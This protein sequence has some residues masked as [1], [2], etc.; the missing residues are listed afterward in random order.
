M[1][2]T[3]RFEFVVK[4]PP[5]ASREV[6]EFIA[7]FRYNQG[8]TCPEPIYK[9]MTRDYQY[10]FAVMLQKAFGRGE[11]RYIEKYN[12]IIWY[13][14]ESCMLYDIDGV[15]RTGCDSVPIQVAANKGINYK[16]LPDIQLS[17][18]RAGVK[19][20]KPKS[21][22]R[23]GFFAVNG[24]KYTWIDLIHKGYIEV[25][26][27]GAL[28]APNFKDLP[29]GMLQVDESVKII[30]NRAFA[31]AHNLVEILLP[32]NL[33][34]IETR[35]FSTC[36]LTDLYVPASVTSIGAAAFDGIPR[37]HY[38]GNAEG[39]PWHAL[40]VISETPAFNSKEYLLENLGNMYEYVPTC[41]IEDCKTKEDCDELIQM[42]S[43]FMSA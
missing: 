1:L 2:D 33:A 20:D 16:R 35:A 31:N 7:D 4:Q 26:S 40:D 36:G 19:F 14:T 9:I 27:T 39:S 24:D 34:V 18:V 13:D 42:L 43:R 25:D 8:E 29:C 17:I 12:K 3:K 6:L 22:N 41:S 11:I 5:G 30:S 28:Y 32:D 21:R 38:S 15:Y 10:Y 23:S 37:V